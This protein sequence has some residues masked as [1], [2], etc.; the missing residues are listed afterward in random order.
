MCD[1]NE[2][3]MEGLRKDERSTLEIWRCGTMRMLLVAAGGMFAGAGFTR[4]LFEKK[5]DVS[6][7]WIAV[8]FMGFYLILYGCRPKGG[9]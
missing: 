3:L 9:R 7:L 5:T 6:F 4:G 8:M 1:V 2:Y